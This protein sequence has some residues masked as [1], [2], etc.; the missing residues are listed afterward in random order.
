MGTKWLEQVGKDGMERK[1]ITGG[2]R[3]RMVKGIKERPRGR[4]EM[5]SP[6]SGGCG[7]G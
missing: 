5:N 3:R 2:E 7:K 4:M 1:S 6:G